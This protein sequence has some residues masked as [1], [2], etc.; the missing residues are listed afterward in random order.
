MAAP[1]GQ[2][3]ASYKC[4]QRDNFGISNVCAFRG[5]VYSL[6]KII[7]KRQL[8]SGR[9]HFQTKNPLQHNGF[10]NTLRMIIFVIMHLVNWI[11]WKFWQILK[12]PKNYNDVV[13]ELFFLHITPPYDCYR[14]YNTVNQITFSQITVISRASFL[15]VIEAPW[16][17]SS[18]VQIY[19]NYFWSQPFITLMKN[20]VWIVRYVTMFSYKKSESCKKRF[21]FFSF[22][23]ELELVKLFQIQL[24]Y[25]KQI[26][27][28]FIWHHIYF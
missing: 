23:R 2:F 19:I 11:I 5:M 4:A 28:N 10:Y 6:T 20:Y 26:Q 24:S 8:P 7:G 3:I 22:W 13:F 17:L 12:Y 18:L 9:T 25:C 27:V 21:S 15:G 1:P 16:D 14:N